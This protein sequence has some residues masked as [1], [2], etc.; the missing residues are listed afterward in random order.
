[1]ATLLLCIIYL[2]FIS[3]GL[4]DSLLGSAWPVMHRDFA[5]PLYF[6][7]MVSAAVT[8]GTVI[9]SLL[10]SRVIRR[11]GTGRVTALSVAMTAIGLLGFSLMP[12]FYWFVVFALPL[13]LG[14]GA[15]DTGLN[16]FVALHYKARHMNWLHCFWGIGA[17]L[18]PVIMAWFISGGEQWRHGYR[19]V[20]FVL[21]GI[22]LVLSA[23]LFLWKPFEAKHQATTEGPGAPGQKNIFRIPGVKAALLGF[24]S[25]VSMEGIIGVWGPTYLVMHR[26][27]NPNT[28]AQWL[29]LY[30]LSLTIGRF[31]SGFVSAFLNNTKLI[32]LGCLFIALG[33]SFLVLPL[34]PFFLFLAFLLIGFGY[35]PVFPSMLHETPR[36]F[37][38]AVS[39][40]IMG[41][42]FA[43]S[44][45]G[46]SCTPM[47]TGLIIS[48]ISMGL[49]PF[50][51]VIYLALLAGSTAFIGVLEKRGK[52]AKV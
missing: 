51:F 11:F 31:L 19:T 4:P 23:T 27:I 33:I 42:Q 40:A 12:S 2:A 49:Y 35:A 41:W 17:G 32:Y 46:A 29:S 34:P 14:A 45:I 24:F 21:A 48:R 1:L 6:A 25:Y 16:N 37:G 8:G 36:R 3:L 44:S 52:L 50:L 47:I 28:A 15:I 38:P 9:S 18:S 30:F 10:S 20:S 13:G 22:A 43:L 26:G 5:V 7:G 39:Q